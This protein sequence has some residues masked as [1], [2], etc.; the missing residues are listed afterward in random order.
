MCVWCVRIG[1]MVLE[2]RF[3][4]RI[5]FTVVIIIPLTWFLVGRSLGILGCNGSCWFLIFFI[6][7][8]G[9]MIKNFVMSWKMALLKKYEPLSLINSNGHPNNEIIYIYKNLIVDCASTFGQTG[10]AQQAD[11][12]SGTNG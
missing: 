3:W 4:L 11:T 12:V 2:R 10:R 1:S 9:L 6:F 7:D 5:R 8:G